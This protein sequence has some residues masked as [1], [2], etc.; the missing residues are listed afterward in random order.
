MNLSSAS[1]NTF[2]RTVPLDGGAGTHRLNGFDE[3]IGE[4][5]LLR[6][7]L[8]RVSEVAPTD[9]TVLLQGDTGTGKELFARALHERSPR[10]PRALV[11]VNCAALPAS[12]I[13]S[14]LFGHER[15][16]FTGAV[17]ARQGRFE[18]A[19]Q[20]TLFLD[21]IGDLPLELQAKLLRVIQEGEF[22]RLGSSHKRRVDVRLIAA[23]HRD[24]R[25]MVADGRFRMDLYYR[26]NVF[27]IRIPSLS[28]R[29]EDIPRLVWHII[30]RR[31]HALRR[32]ITHVPAA[33]MRAL[34]QFDWPGNV[35]EL[36]N[37]VERAMIRSTGDTLVLHDDLVPVGS[38]G[39]AESSTALFVV[40]RRHI[41]A[42]L[43]KCNWR[44]NGHGNAAEQLCLHPNT[45]RFRMRKLG[46]NRPSRILKAC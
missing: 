2:D 6:A 23:T 26:L 33:V 28:D 38:Q 35:R 3:I 24:L 14:E 15:G 32:T 13:E 4:S 37:V 19:D 9:A 8:A 34:Q 42:V 29:R 43:Q 36:E 22:E 31:R 18:L 30:D 45:L 1:W 40:E 7:S 41:E 11:C 5:P 46:I 27:P 25:A 20:G 21:E 16:A 12:L 17:G 39:P 44:I 10:R